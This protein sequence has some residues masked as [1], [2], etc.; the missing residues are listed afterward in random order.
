MAVFI[1]YIKYMWAG[2]MIYCKYV[3]SEQRSDIISLAA[4]RMK[5]RRKGHHERENRRPKYRALEHSKFRGQEEEYQQSTR[6]KS[7]LCVK[8]AKS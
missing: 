6:R 3:T 2:L 5:D 7:S 8:S 1:I 4:V